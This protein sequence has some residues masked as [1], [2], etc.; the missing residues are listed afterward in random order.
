MSVN[1]FLEVLASSEPD[2]I[3]DLIC[4]Q[5]NVEKF[6]EKTFLCPGLIGRILKCR[7]TSKDITEEAFGF[8]PTLYISFLPIY[9]SDEYEQ[10]RNSIIKV[11][12]VVLNYESGDAVL[13]RENEQ[14][15]FQRLRGKLILNSQYFTLENALNR[16]EDINLPYNI[17]ELQSPLL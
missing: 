12:M 2:Q 5:L 14:V 6:D 8:R 10:G 4:N 15:L 9:N 1:Y 16:V 11:S 13:T 17:Q 7:E 3:L